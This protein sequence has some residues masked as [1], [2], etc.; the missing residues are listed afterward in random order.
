MKK[1]KFNRKIARLTKILSKKTL[2]YKNAKFL[3]HYLCQKL[4]NFHQNIAQ[5]SPI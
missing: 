3:K 5:S 2:N 4:T 1:F